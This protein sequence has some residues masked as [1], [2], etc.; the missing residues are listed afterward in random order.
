[1]AQ[2]AGGKLAKKLYLSFVSLLR[3][4]WNVQGAFLIA[5]LTA[6]IARLILLPDATGMLAETW[7]QSLQPFLAAWA[8]ALCCYIACKAVSTGSLSEGF[9]YLWSD[10]L[11]RRNV[12]K[13]LPAIVAASLLMN[14]FTHFKSNIPSFN[15]YDLDLVLAE[16]DRFLHFG[17]DPWRFVESLLGY[18][19]VTVV[20]DKTYYLWFFAVFISMA[21]LVGMPDRYGIRHQFMLSYAFVW[22]LLGIVCAIALSSVGPIFYDRV[23][24]GH[25]PYTDLVRNLEQTEIAWD[26]TTMQVRETLWSAYVNDLDTTIS[27]ISAMPSIHNAMCVLLFLAARHVNRW[28]A[29]AAGVFALTIFVGS[30]HLGWHYAIDAYVSALGVALLWKIAGYLTGDASRRRAKVLNSSVLA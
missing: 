10:I 15:P 29:A 3:L 11:T 1:M 30:V 20:I 26:L 19:A 12:A 2:G 24:G 22:G 5:S 6:L 18:G 17:V 4:N 28:L 21:V 13:A 27:G 16:A 23:Y 8:I 25:S 9:R 14:S 7:L